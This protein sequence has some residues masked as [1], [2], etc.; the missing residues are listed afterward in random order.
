MERIELNDFLKAEGYHNLTEIPN[1][2]LCGLMRFAFTTGLCIGLDE[3]GY[4]GRYCY[5]YFSDAFSAIKEWNGEG[6]PSGEW[7]KYKGW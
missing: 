1:K 6:D 5:E 3:S 2:G 4:S 7:I